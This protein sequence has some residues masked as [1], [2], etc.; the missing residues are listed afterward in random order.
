MARIFPGYWVQ[1][2]V[3]ALILAPIA[4]LISPSVWTVQSAGQ[5]I[6][7]NL[8]T[9][10][11]QYLFDGTVFPHF[12]AWNGSAW[13]LMYELMAYAGCL[14][15]FSV[16]W[17]RH[18]VITTSASALVALGGFTIVAPFAGVTTNLY[19]N[20][21]YLGSYFAAGMLAY[22]LRDRIPVRWL[23]IGISTV[24]AVVLLAIPGGD[25]FAQIP[26][27]YALLAAGVALP[28]RVGSTN[29]ISYGVYIYAFPVQQ[30]V[31]M[32]GAGELLHLVV[33]ITITLVLAVGSWHW[34]ERPA[35]VGAGRFIARI[36]KCLQ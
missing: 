22:A 1:L 6:V 12:D 23:L 30:I 2:L 31:A 15:V 16:P 35:N 24:A 29:D 10:G 26:I 18:H 8:S 25:G 14:A 3:V 36:R 32:L 13:T 11:L 21:A 20:T 9:F 33:S 4:T 27:A 7:A 28:T 34:V 5:Y 19:L 17:C